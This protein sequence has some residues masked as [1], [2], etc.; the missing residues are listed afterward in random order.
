MSKGYA[1]GEDGPEIE[2]GS[3]F[4]RERE[5]NLPGPSDTLLNQKYNPINIWIDYNCDTILHQSSYY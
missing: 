3:G 5:G 2:T 4:E 1:N